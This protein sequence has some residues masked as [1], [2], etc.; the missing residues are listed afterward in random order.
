[1]PNPVFGRVLQRGMEIPAD[2]AGTSPPV[3]FHMQR[4]HESSRCLCSGGLQAGILVWGL[5]ELHDE[6][7]S[8]LFSTREFL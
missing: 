1:M 8:D 6:V 7:M 2:S 4:L 3:G 5:R